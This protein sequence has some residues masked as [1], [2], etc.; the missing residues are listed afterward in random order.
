MFP[1]APTSGEA[2][3]LAARDRAARREAREGDF[4][5]AADEVEKAVALAP[6][7]GE[8]RRA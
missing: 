1:E 3:A 2:R 7:Q 8:Q 6:E 4:E 5:G